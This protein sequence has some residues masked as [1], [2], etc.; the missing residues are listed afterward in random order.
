MIN[1]RCWQ[2]E[3]RV[4][5]LKFV[6]DLLKMSNKINIKLVTN[7]TFMPNVYSKKTLPVSEFG[8]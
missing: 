2:V 7:D 6:F 5:R 4:G 8:S 1:G 3:L